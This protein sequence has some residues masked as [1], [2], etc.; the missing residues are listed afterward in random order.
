MITL[1]AH[2]GGALLWPENS[3]T[4]FRNA[5]A[6]PIEEVECDVHLSLD[7]EVM[8][9]HDATLDRMTEGTG[10]IAHY[11]AEQLSLIPIRGL[12]EGMPRLAEL[13]ELVAES[14]KLL[15]LEIK[16]DHENRHDP[17][18]LAAVRRELDRVPADVRV[19]S[20]QPA[21]LAP[22][23]FDEQDLLIRPQDMGW[24]DSEL[25]NAIALALHCSGIGFG[26]ETGFLPETLP[27]ITGITNIWRADTEEALVRS[28]AMRPDSITTDD[29]VL[30][31]KLRDG[32]MKP[33]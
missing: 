10:P 30:A 12:T 13:L 7:G 18:L 5:V 2:R 31:L 24:H 17:A 21:T 16:A 8:V 14:G 15:R 33:A 9:H 4:A 32:V 22:G 3:L 1:C 11:T 20:F 19:M 23:L 25:L 27:G 28:F 29:P 6:L 26:Y